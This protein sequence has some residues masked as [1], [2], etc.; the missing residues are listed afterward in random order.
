MS[1]TEIARYMQSKKPRFIEALG[2]ERN[3]GSYIS[4]VLLAVANDESGALQQCQVE[5][6]YH[7]ALRAA[8]LRLSVDPSTGQ[9]YL[10]PFSGRATLI[11]GYKGLYDMAVRTNKYRYI[12]VGPVYE[13][14]KVEVNR[15]S[16]F[17]SLSGTKQG[18]GI[19]GW[20]GAFEMFN[21]FG[22]T[23]YMTVEEIHEHAKKHSKSY[24]HKRSGWQT[25]P[26]AM[27]RKTVLRLLLRKWGYLDPTD[28][29]VLEEIEREPDALDA[30]FV[31]DIDESYLPDVVYGGEGPS[32]EDQ[33][34]SAA[35]TIAEHASPGIRG[36]LVGVLDEIT[37]NDRHLLGKHLY[38]KP[39]S[40]TWTDG[41]VLA[42]WRY[43]SIVQDEETKEWIPDLA[44]AR[45]LTQMHQRA[46]AAD[47]QMKMPGVGE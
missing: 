30:E 35:K 21:G 25:D 40:K 14:E 8:A 28:V 47:G 33:L 32:L 43:L 1:T 2:N 39:S 16:G 45:E 23:L 3:A 11:V 5:S 6:I 31:S 26:Q 9:A 20:I 7:S 36:A 13:G 17:H 12:N 44:A 38:E 29:S 22:H 42:L 34:R 15:I 10:V 19:I 24:G 46:Q 4:S 37:K 18:N 27:E 41:E